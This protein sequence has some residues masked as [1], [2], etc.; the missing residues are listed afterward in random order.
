[1][2]HRRPRNSS[3]SEPAN[4]YERSK[5]HRGIEVKLKICRT[6]SRTFIQLI[7]CDLISAY[8]TTGANI[9]IDFPVRTM[10]VTCDTQR[11]PEKVKTEPFEEDH[12]EANELSNDTNWNSWNN[13]SKE[14][15]Y[16]DCNTDWARWN[17]W[18]KEEYDDRA[19]QWESGNL[20]TSTCKE[21]YDDPATQWNSGNWGTSMCSWIKREDFVIPAQK[22]LKT[23]ESGCLEDHIGLALDGAPPRSAVRQFFDRYVGLRSSKDDFYFSH[24]RSEEGVVATLITPALGDRH[25]E[26][27]QCSN[28]KS[29]EQSAATV[30]V[31]DP[32]AL[33]IAACLPPPLATLRKM[34]DG[35]HSRKK[36]LALKGLS[37]KEVAEEILREIYEKLR[38]RGCRTALWDGNL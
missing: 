17:T 38:D 29:A 35:Y 2:C 31:Q 30:F 5:V 19:A 21:E 28:E 20:D 27:M 3:C 32:E 12:E 15:S 16:D 8:C 4:V 24:K 9:G 34:A 1:M 25:F 13:W 18:T 36:Q 6:L 26:G 23:G 7:Q 11:C 10:A 33:Q 37:T 14:E 22:K